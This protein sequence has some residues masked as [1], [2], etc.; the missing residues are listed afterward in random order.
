MG[1]MIELI[2]ADGHQFAAYKAIPAGTPRGGLVVMQE[3]FGV[4]THIRAV[5][6]GYAAD[7]YVAVA[8]AMY[9]RAQRN[10]DTGYTQ[11]EIEAGVAIMQKLDW[12]HTMQ[13]VDAAVAEARKAGK[14]AIVG[15]CWGGTVSWVAAA[16]TGGLAA[17]I[18]Y[19]PGGI[20][21]FADEAPRCPV[22]C[23][24]GEQD[25]SPTPDVAKSVIARHPDVTAF[26]YHAGH[27]FNCDHRP[28]F[29]AEAAA[30]A[31]L[32]TLEF[33]RKHIG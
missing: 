2:A 15:F 6:D 3:I 9:D 1:S 18:A 32:R 16:R 8:P 27:G 20:A 14:A 29:N 5:A 7:G 24:F 17:A 13:D 28:S 10:Y 25:K 22:M 23:H 11:P 4:N 12:T 33:L 21:N 31:R 26:Y 19:Y 30:L